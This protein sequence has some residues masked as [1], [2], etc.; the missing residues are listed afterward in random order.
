VVEGERTDIGISRGQQEDTMNTA[1]SFAPARTNLGAWSLAW[2]GGP[3]IGIANGV[4]RR[5]LYDKSLGELRAHQLSTAIAMALFSSYI[6]L[7]D[8]RWPIA[9]ARDAAR[10]GADWVVL[11]AAFEV[12]FGH[13]VAGTSWRNLL[14]DYN[15]S[16][17]RVWSLVLLTLGVAPSVARMARIRR[18]QP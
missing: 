6:T 5:G 9:T 8:R 13:Y 18:S 3:V 14:R 16:E 15:V 7:L 17:G 12:I 2:L 10:I 1:T 11:T 4:V